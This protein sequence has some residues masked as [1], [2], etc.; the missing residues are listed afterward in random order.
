ML[1]FTEYL[2]FHK[3]LV[4]NIY[5]ICPKKPYTPCDIVKLKIKDTSKSM[6]LYGTLGKF[7]AK[8]TYYKYRK[9]L[10]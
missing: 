10:R 6:R 9:I 5:R 2:I 1:R 4:R 3:E 7:D 8:D